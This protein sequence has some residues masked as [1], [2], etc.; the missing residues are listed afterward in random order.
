[1][2][3]ARSPEFRVFISSTFIDLQPERE[4]L[5]KK[6]FP[7]V[8]ALCRERGVEFTE[9]DLRWGITQEES[10]SG[11]TIRICLEEIDRCPY[12][13]GILGSR[14][15]WRP[16]IA[17]IEKDA[18]LLKRYPWLSELAQNDRS[19]I[20]MEMTLGILSSASSAFIYEQTE[21]LHLIEETDG[22]PFDALKAKLRS[23]LPYRQFASPEILGELVYQEILA[24][25]DRDWPLKDKESA[26]EAE[27]RA[28]EAFVLNRTHS[29]IPHPAYYERFE[30]FAEGD[31]PPLVVWGRSGLG[32]SAFMAYLTSEYKQRHP[33]A[34]VVRHFVGATAGASTPVDIMR[35]VMLEIK[36]RYDLPDELP[37]DDAKFT[38]DFPSW[39]AKVR[40]E[41]KLVL[42]ID[43]VNQLSGIG[44][45]MH[46]LP[47]FIPAN[48]RLV[49]STTIDVP[50][51]QLRKRN[52]QEFEIEPL[53]AKQRGRIATEFLE[54]YHKRLA[55]EQ[56][57]AIVGEP[58]LASPLF[59]RTVLEELRIHGRHSA[60][61]TH[62]ETYLACSDERDLFHRVLSR[63]ERDH[64]ADVVRSVMTAIWAS[65]FGLTETELM[66]VTGLS[67]LALSDFLIAL[68]FHLMQRGGLFTFFHNYLREAVE[69]RYLP[70]S[71]DR[72][73]LHSH[74]ARYFAT[75]EYDVRRRDEEPWQWQ[76]AEDLDAL[77]DCLMD[78]Q[79]VAMFS[80]DKEVYEHFSYWK[81][82]PEIG[83]DDG[84]VERLLETDI[85][86]DRMFD[87][88]VNILSL[89]VTAGKYSLGESILTQSA[90]FSSLLSNDDQ[91]IL[92]IY[93]LTFTIENHLGHF[94]KVIDQAKALI[95]D[96]SLE[97]RDKDFYL[98]LFDQYSFATYS[99]G[100]YSEAEEA[101]MTA[102]RK[103]D[104]P[105][106][107]YQMIM[108]YKSL[109]AFLMAQQKF[110]ES[111]EICNKAWQ[112][113]KKVFGAHHPESADCQMNFAACFT[114]QN[115]FIDA[116]H[117]YSEAGSVFATT[118]GPT[119]HLSLHCGIN[120]AY[121]EVQQGKLI[122][123][124]NKCLLQLELCRRTLGDNSLNT[125]IIGILTGFTYLKQKD[126]INAKHY[127][128]TY[129]PLLT[130][131]RG[132]NHPDV[133]RYKARLEEINEALKE[134]PLQKE[135]PERGAL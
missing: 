67:R 13:I 68:E 99:L 18:D 36:A 90:A 87:A 119:H 56:L 69:L 52:W 122:E 17:E 104:D 80:D 41:E 88:Y 22:E 110:D 23:E 94:Q 93:D 64:G 49:I 79:M 35:H 85:N 8:R 89:L 133:I 60:L 53:D 100:R 103:A 129:L 96:S 47:E 26:L 9:I 61:D 66:E 125:A 15:G 117:H 38:E 77:K 42:A 63:M 86:S 131:F 128:Q 31:G 2:P 106:T 116:T 14:Y 20:E 108:R 95:E 118:V 107:N 29:Y 45:E 84:Y 127:Y 21:K 92:D 115:K 6:V 75:R 101:T 59:L 73:S 132:E 11:K 102:L 82:L 19:I 65:R 48:V 55:D 37:T 98:K 134:T 124:Q 114:L 3:Q 135:C 34:F 5:I 72:K 109:G 54:R 39:L 62:L 51:E 33:D 112:L 40:S 111:E 16:G 7:R 43:A 123:A 83:F 71:G 121:L 130:T 12:F 44:N 46:W 81:S 4:Q 30:A 27:R 76:Q 10:R 120:V 70:T 78:P 74:L 32:K 58:K 113:C 25:L 97:P 91:R 1:M 105:D 126:Y 57:A 24:L 50:L 28:H